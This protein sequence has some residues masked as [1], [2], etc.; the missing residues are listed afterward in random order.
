M[1][2]GQVFE[3]PCAGYHA[4]DNTTDLRMAVS[5]NGMAACL[6]REDCGAQQHE[7]RLLKG[8]VTDH[9]GFYRFC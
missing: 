9:N 7:M 2:N 6:T 3:C 1:I 8:L 4:K 5:Q